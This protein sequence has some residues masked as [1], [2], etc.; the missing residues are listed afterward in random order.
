M[1]HLFTVST[2]GGL[3]W[4]MAATTTHAGEHFLG[5]T[6][7]AETLPA[8]ARE[9]YVIATERA[10]K[11]AGHYAATD[12]QAE[13]EYGV[14]DRFSAS[15]ALRAMTLETDGIVIDG[16]LPGARDFAF[17]SAGAEIG[18]LYNFLRPAK[19][20]IGL[21]AYFSLEYAWL[22]PHSGR[23]KDT[24]STEL[25]LALQKYFFEGELVWMGNLG[26]ETTYADRAPIEDLPEGF[27]WPTD[28]EMEIELTVATGLSY[29]LAPRWFIGA[30][31]E[32][33]TEFETEVGQERWSLFAGP[34]LHYGSQKWWATLTWF[35]QVAGGGEQF[36]AQ[37]DTHLHLIEKTK[38]EFR[39]KIGLN[40]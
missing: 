23:R 22:D 30:E 7:G 21:S 9:L 15:F 4:L 29:R 24:I 27:D 2:I 34:S 12:Y 16:Y 20:A 17:K 39:L 6:K 13:F 5:Y 36:A 31:T 10:G 25:G 1:K 38:T 18:G 26:L 3:G 8:G 37:D 35:G 14:T 11:G 32:F 40:F 19:D 28:P 33:Q